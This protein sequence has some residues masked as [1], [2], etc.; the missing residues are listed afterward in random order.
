MY[1]IIENNQIIDVMET[2]HFVKYLPKT[3]RSITVGE[4]QANGILSS[5]QSTIY[6]IDGTPN[7]YPEGYRNVTY[8]KIEEDEYKRL[9]EQLKINTAL[10]DRIRELEKQMRELQKTLVLID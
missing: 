6:H 9:T 4:R 5:N 2:L 7:V 8:Q 3:K 1:K 10:E